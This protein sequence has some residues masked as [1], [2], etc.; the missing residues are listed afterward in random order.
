M[1]RTALLPLAIAGVMALTA[2]G[3]TGEAQGSSKPT[4]TADVGQASAVTPLDDETI[5]KAESEGEV[6]MYTNAEDQQIAP[7]KKAFEEAY[8]EIELRSLPLSDDEMFQRYDTE[9]ASG[10]DTADVLMNSDPVAW[11]SFVEAGNLADYE[12]PN[13]PNLPDYAVLQPGLYAM[14]LDPVVALFNKTIIPEDKQPTSMAE[15][16]EMA[17][18]LDGKIATTD[19]SVPTQFAASTA[20]IQKYGAEGWKH[21]E[22]LGRHSEVEASNG[23]LATKLAQG[24]YAVDFFVSGAVRAFIVDDVAKVVNYR[25]LSDGTPL[26]PRG[27]GVT[28]EAPHPNAARVFV[29]WLLSVEGQ[30]A[31][32]QGGFTPYR[33]GVP[34]DFGL[35]QVVE[36]IGG[37]EN[38]AVGSYDRD[39]LD[40]YDAHITRWKKAFG[41]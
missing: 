6:L 22:T 35:P 3:E 17:P 30:A 15:L 9:T 40:G 18:Q 28:K 16:A 13:T 39:V 31:A 21:L 19:I 41:R 7:L 24:Q 4:A 23:P 33:D 34:C 11:L 27:V 5:A 38:L 37:E 1:K 20:F 2:C 14:S 26:T 36:E 25:Y 10:T 12:D 29:N 8:P 32:C